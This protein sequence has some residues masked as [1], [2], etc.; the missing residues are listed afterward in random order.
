MVASNTHHS[1]QADFFKEVFGNIHVSQLKF[2]SKA[3]E[4]AN[5]QTGKQNMT[6]T[7]LA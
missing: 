5:V 3:I 2:L 4:L 7:N 1:W 6:V